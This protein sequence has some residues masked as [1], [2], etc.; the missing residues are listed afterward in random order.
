MAQSYADLEA[1]TGDDRVIAEARLR[2]TQCE[3]WEGPCRTLYE[4]D[5]KY[6]EGDS[7][8]NWQWPDGMPGKR[9][10]RPS[11]TI[12]KIRQHNLQIINEGKLN[13]QSIK[14]RAVSDDASSKGAEIFEGIARHIEYISN[15]DSAYA[16]AREFQ[17]KAGIGY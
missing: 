2:F 9:G 14:Y 13:K 11:L 17:V 5:L 1:L 16:T 8:N 12:N 15:A 6:A 7:Y 4:K 3:E 10:D